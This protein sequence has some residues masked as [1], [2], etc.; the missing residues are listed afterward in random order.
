MKKYG[1]TQIDCENNNFLIFDSSSFPIPSTIHFKFSTEPSSSFDKVI[2]FDYDLIEINNELT[3]YNN[4]PTETNNRL[5]AYY[6]EL[7][8]TNNELTQINNELKRINYTIYTKS[9][10]N[11]EIAIKNTIRISNKSN[12][13][14]NIEN[15]NTQ[16]IDQNHKFRY[17]IF[18]SSESV[19]NINNINYNLT[20]FNIDKNQARVGD[21]FG[22]NLLISFSCK[23][24][25]K[26]EN[27][28]NDLSSEISTVTL[29]LIIA[30]GVLV[31]IIIVVILVCYFKKNTGKKDDKKLNVKKISNENKETVKTEIKEIINLEIEC[32]LIV[33]KYY[34]IKGLNEHIFKV[35]VFLN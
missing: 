28:K 17:V 13:E 3:E 34:R 12:D 22:N 11:S 33:I 8:E 21:R 26:I 5:T 20:Y 35:L 6:H 31:I 23:G 19:E 29:I 30:G 7:T 1:S 14:N 15:T 4:E 24:F 18:P 9:D 10:N 16:Y 32:N 27:T 25:L 2:S